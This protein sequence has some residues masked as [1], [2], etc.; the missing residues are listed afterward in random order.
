VDRHPQPVLDRFFGDQPA[1]RRTEGSTCWCRG[2]GGD[3]HIAVAELHFVSFR[4]TL[5]D[6]SWADTFPA[7]GVERIRVVGGMGAVSILRS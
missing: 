7:A 6:F 2:D 3:D 4:T 1:P 5:H